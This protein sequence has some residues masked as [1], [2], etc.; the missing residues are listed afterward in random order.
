MSG[1]FRDAPGVYRSRLLTR[2]DWLD[3]GFGTR[4]ADPHPAPLTLKQV[5][6][7]LVLRAPQAPGCEGDA[8]VTSQPGVV[9]AV[10][11]A[12]CVPILLAGPGNRVAAAVHAGWKGTALAIVRRTVERMHADFGSRPAHLYAAIGPS[13]GACCYQVGPEVAEQ[14]R[15]L[16]PERG[17]LH[18]PTHLDLPEANRRLLLAAGL[19]EDHIAVSGL[20]T[21]C[22]PREFHSW[23]RDREKAGRMLS[24]IGIREAS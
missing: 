22:S 9:V 4:H 6:S 3:H 11:T 23:R 7:D 24:S 14:F 10:R 19:P 13:I 5:H 20:C 18:R 15:H 16:F 8:L 21:F 12:D 17:D 1:F 2:F